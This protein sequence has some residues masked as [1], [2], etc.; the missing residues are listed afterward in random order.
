V[1]PPSLLV[2]L[3]LRPS[4]VRLYRKTPSIV[5]RLESAELFSECVHLRRAG[6]VYVHGP[7]RAF[8][9]NMEFRVSRMIE[10][11]MSCASVEANM[12]YRTREYRHLCM[13]N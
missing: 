13:A 12:S 11:R 4:A 2:K 8:S 9:A 1:T 10:M 7:D 6:C 3:S 5:E